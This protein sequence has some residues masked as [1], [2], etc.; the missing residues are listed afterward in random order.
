MK[1][2]NALVFSQLANEQKILKNL[3]KILPK[4]KAFK[5]FI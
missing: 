5:D 3:N 4:T 1:S 2:L